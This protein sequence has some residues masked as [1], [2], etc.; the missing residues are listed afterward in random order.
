MQAIYGLN[1]NVHEAITRREERMGRKTEGAN[2]LK[3]KILGFCN[4][5]RVLFILFQTSYFVVLKRLVFMNFYRTLGLK[6]TKT[7]TFKVL[8]NRTSK[9]A[10][11]RLG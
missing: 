2:G 9:F 1:F 8:L 5:L 11:F 3:V 7:H 4:H 6:D 10:L